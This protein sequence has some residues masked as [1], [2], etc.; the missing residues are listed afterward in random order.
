M[1]IFGPK[2]TSLKAKMIPQLPHLMWYA[3]SGT[4]RDT[5]LQRMQ[6]YERAPCV[7]QARVSFSSG[8][9]APGIGV[10]PCGTRREYR[11]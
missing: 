7:G 5:I 2:L 1:M 9:F 6:R 11:V 3:L 4:L 8:L 10:F